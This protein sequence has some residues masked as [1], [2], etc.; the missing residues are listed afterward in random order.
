MLTRTPEKKIAI[1]GKNIFIRHKIKCKWFWKKACLAQCLHL[2]TGRAGTAGQFFTLH[3]SYPHCPWMGMRV[4][5]PVGKGRTLGSIWAC[6]TKGDHTHCALLCGTPEVCFKS[7]IKGWAEL[8]LWIS[9]S[10]SS[11]AN[12]NGFHEK[13]FQIWQKIWTYSIATCYGTYHELRIY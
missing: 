4:S 6:L 7:I 9:N 13:I 11:L 1:C 5:Y 10:L 8:F 2:P 12:F 3:Y